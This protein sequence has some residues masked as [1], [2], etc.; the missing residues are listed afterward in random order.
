MG[1]RRQMVVRERNGHRQAR[2][3]VHVPSERAVMQ[4]RRTHGSDPAEAAARLV[5]SSVSG[6]RSGGGYGITF[7]GDHLDGIVRVRLQVQFLGGNEQILNKPFYE[8]ECKIV[9]S[10]KGSLKVILPSTVSG[11]KGLNSSNIGTLCITSGHFVFSPPKKLAHAHMYKGQE[12]L[13]ISRALFRS[14]KGSLAFYGTHDYPVCV[15]K[16]VVRAPSRRPGG[17]IAA[18][19]KKTKTTRRRRMRR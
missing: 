9:S 14:S 3:G 16:S 12:T 17:K 8:A 2:A 13:D 5:I 11:G 7:N 6:A 18:R 1:R 15:F 19:T 4:P 10:S